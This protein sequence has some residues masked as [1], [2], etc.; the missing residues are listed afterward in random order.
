[1]SNVR[2]LVMASVAMLAA[3]CSTTPSQPKGPDLSGP[4]VLTTESQMGAQDSDMIIRQT[5]D[6][7]AGTLT[8]QMGSVDFT[9]NVAGSAVEF[10]FMFNAQGT[11]LKIDYTGVV[12]GDSMKGKA[13]FGSFGEGSFT[14]KRKAM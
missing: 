3:A 4:W 13:V 11:D 8:S 7:L 2:Q 9:G 5:G 1:M 6:A 12:E 10:G 14:A